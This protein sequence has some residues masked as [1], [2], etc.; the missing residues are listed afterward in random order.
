M[1]PGVRGSRSGTIDRRRY[2][3]A[4]A[5]Q[6]TPGRTALRSLLAAIRELASGRRRGRTRRFAT[7]RRTGLAPR[8]L[9]T[10]SS[11]SRPAGGDDYGA[12]ASKAPT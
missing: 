5:K 10:M 9:A 8:P 3:K 11:T 4:K 2:A 12:A 7:V 6:T 1:A